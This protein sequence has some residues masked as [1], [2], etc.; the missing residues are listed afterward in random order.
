MFRTPYQAI[1]A[2]GLV[3]LDL[4]AAPVPISTLA[5]VAAFMYLDSCAL[6]HGSVVVLCQ[7]RPDGYQPDFE[8]PDKLYSAVPVLGTIA[9]LG[10]IVQMRPIVQITSLSIVGVA[11]YVLYARERAELTSLVGEAVAPEVR[12][13]DQ[14]TDRYTV[15]V[16]VAIPA[17]EDMPLRY[18][19]QLRRR[20]PR[21]R[22]A[23][24]HPPARWSAARP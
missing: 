14:A 6:E 24:R 8:I 12:Q 17:T 5:D 4:I 15:V 22:R 23:A 21:G 11:W 20:R 13:G 16:P 19:R 2:T 7:A 9:C 10:V 3:I 1:V 18:G